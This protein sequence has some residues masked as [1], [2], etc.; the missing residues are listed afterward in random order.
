MIIKSAYDLITVRFLLSLNT[1]QFADAIG[2]SNS[3]VEKIEAFETEPKRMLF[4]AARAVCEKAPHSSYL[5]ELYREINSES[6]VNF[7]LSCTESNSRLPKMA[8]YSCGCSHPDVTFTWRNGRD[9][10]I[11]DAE[12]SYCGRITD[13]QSIG[14]MRRQ[15]IVE[16]NNFEPFDECN[17]SL[18]KWKSNRKRL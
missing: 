1:K 5:K 11:L 8:R 18:S 13:C 9:R 2:V 6:Y 4:L 17:Y 7:L 16:D 3:M 12:C 10:S 15:L 14:E